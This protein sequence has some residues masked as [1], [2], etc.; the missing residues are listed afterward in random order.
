MG[1]DNI[2]INEDSVNVT[3]VDVTELQNGSDTLSFSKKITP[4]T[5]KQNFKDAAG[6]LDFV[7]NLSGIFALDESLLNC[8]VS[9]AGTPNTIRELIYGINTPNVIETLV[10]PAQPVTP[11]VPIFGRGT[12]RIVFAQWGY[13]FTPPDDNPLI[14][15][16]V[17]PIVTSFD[18]AEDFGSPT[19]DE[20]LPANFVVTADYPQTST[21][22]NVPETI[23]ATSKPKF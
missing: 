23:L 20:I 6:E 5:L 9:N 11:D 17:P 1:K 2:S 8:E 15:G 14:T 12:G 3:L 19:L 18:L 10:Q 4:G 7:V 16:I 13:G 22:F 21:S